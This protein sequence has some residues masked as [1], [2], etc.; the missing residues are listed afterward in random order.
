MIWSIILFIL[1]FFILVKGSDVLIDGSRSIAKRLHISNWVIGITV[2]GIGTS[3]PEFSITLFSALQGKADIGLGAIIG[4]NTFNILMILGLVALIYPISAKKR[5]VSWDL[6][7]NVLAIFSAA[8]IA[9]FPVIGGGFFEITRGEGLLFLLLFIIWIFREALRNGTDRDTD[10][11]EPNLKIFSLHLSFIMILG[12][13]A[14]VIFGGEW[15]VNGAKTIAFWLGASEATVGLT[16]V[17]I[18]T[19]LPELAVSLRAAYRRNFGISLGNIVGSN[20][21]DF[22]GILGIAGTFTAI[23]IPRE[24]LL[25]F[26]VT[27]VSAIILMTMMLTGVR[28]VLQRWQGAVMISAYIFYLIFLV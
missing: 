8:V 24:L 25:D 17:A 9:V 19:S 18:G 16:I 6:T 13:L 20:I 15:V 10:E 22:W 12:G 14:G 7:V 11:E 28:Y 1:G 26:G 23:K 4:S 21:F 2:I 3:I 27:F 5:W